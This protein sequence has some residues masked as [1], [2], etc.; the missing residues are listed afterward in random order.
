MQKA[1]QH[2]AALNVPRTGVEPARPKRALAPQASVSTNSTIW[3]WSYC[4]AQ[5]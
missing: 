2:G 4:E 1:A 3:A 5:I